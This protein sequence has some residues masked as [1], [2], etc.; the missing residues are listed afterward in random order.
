MQ[1]QTGPRPCQQSKALV[2]LPDRWVPSQTT[3]FSVFGPPRLWCSVEVRRKGVNRSV[4]LP[5]QFVPLSTDVK[6]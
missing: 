4:V 5:A 1:P 2:A 6:W 3:C